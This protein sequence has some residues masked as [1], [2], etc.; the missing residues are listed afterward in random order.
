MSADIRPG[1][2]EPK[3]ARDRMWELVDRHGDDYL[4][5]GKRVLRRLSRTIVVVGIAVVL[6]L[7][8]IAVIVGVALLR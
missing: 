1:T 8:A 4:Q 2:P 3:R 5:E 6:A 7:I